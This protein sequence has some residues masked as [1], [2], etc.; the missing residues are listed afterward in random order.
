M[1]FPNVE[2]S[3]RKLQHPGFVVRTYS[4][5]MLRVFATTATA[6]TISYN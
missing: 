6:T 3:S 4:A 5:T 2:Q 1:H